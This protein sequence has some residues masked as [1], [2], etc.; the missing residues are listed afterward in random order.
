MKEI[1]NQIIYA[2]TSR[3]PAHQKIVYY[4]MDLLQI[5]K[6]SA[7]RRI[8]GDIPFS[9]EELLLI[10]QNL[11]ISLDEIFKQ[12]FPNRSCF[13]LSMR[14]LSDPIK[15][16]EESLQ[17][18][19]EFIKKVA[20]A[21]DSEVIMAF[22][23]L[24]MII[25]IKHDYVFKFLFY[26]YITQTSMMPLN[27]PFLDLVLPPQIKELREEYEYYFDQ[28][29][30]VTFILDER[31]IIRFIQKI[32]YYYNRNLITKEE[33]SLIQKDLKDI[34]DTTYIITQTGKNKIGSKNNIYLSFFD[35]SSTSSY[36][37]FDNEELIRIWINTIIPVNMNGRDIIDI[38]KKWFASIKKQSTLITQSGE[39]KQAEFLNT[40]REYVEHLFDKQLD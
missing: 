13:D 31:L 5:S 4:L 40:Q 3:I 15:G 28:I 2:I 30:E 20:S 23:R 37:R 24:S 32:Q 18:N 34:I 12:H 6:E 39:E 27:Y 21:Q 10:T 17:R 11:K 8:R 16:L 25:H 29:K 35:I 19:N 1:N 33:A 9:I 7:Y 22:N 14:L 36:I 26:R 38:Q